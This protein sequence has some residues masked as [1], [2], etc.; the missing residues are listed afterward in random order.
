MFEF[1]ITNHQNFQFGLLCR[2]P[3]NYCKICRFLRHH[4]EPNLGTNKIRELLVSTSSFRSESSNYSYL[5]YILY[6][7]YYVLIIYIYNRW[8]WELLWIKILYYLIQDN[9]SA[10]SDNS[11]SE[12]YE[13]IPGRHPSHTINHF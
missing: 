1:D 4:L 9:F 13:M 2:T 10:E 8:R 6:N 7:T 5:M 11:R 3:T 12:D